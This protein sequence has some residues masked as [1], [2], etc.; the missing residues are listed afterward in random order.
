MRKI[1]AVLFCVS[2]AGCGGNSSSS[3]SATDGPEA[4]SN[5]SESAMAEAGQQSTPSEGGTGPRVM[6]ENNFLG[7]RGF[8]RNRR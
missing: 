2:L 5:I 7:N 8:R 3:S 6:A 1:F 4:A